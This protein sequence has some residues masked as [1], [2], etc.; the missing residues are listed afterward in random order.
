MH[1]SLLDV[2]QLEGVV[3]SIADER[4]CVVI[5]IGVNE[6]TVLAKRGVADVVM[7]NKESFPLLIG[8][9]VFAFEGIGL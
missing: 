9:A 4:R 6:T 2:S 7:F 5:Y 3:R 1:S 8:T